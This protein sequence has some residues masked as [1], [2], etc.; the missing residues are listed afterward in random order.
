[1]LANTTNFEKV[2]CVRNVQQLYSVLA[3]DDFVARGVF[4][5]CKALSVEIVFISAIFLGEELSVRANGEIR[6][7]GMGLVRFKEVVESL[8]R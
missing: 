8:A 4:L 6:I 1:M 7:R 5:R 2:L 3:K